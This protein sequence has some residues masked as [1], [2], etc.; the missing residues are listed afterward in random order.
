MSILPLDWREVFYF[1]IIPNGSVLA[2]DDPLVAGLSARRG[3]R[4]R[5]LDQPHGKTEMKRPTR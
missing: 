2:G 3:T 5:P 1:S 4:T